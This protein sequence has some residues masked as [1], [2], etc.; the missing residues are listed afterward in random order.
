LKLDTLYPS[1]EHVRITIEP[2][3]PTEFSVKLRIPAW[4]RNA[5]VALNGKDLAIE[6]QSDGY[7]RIQRKWNNSD[8]I[9]LTLKLEP[10]VVLGN[11]RNEGKIAVMYGP[12]VLAADGALISADEQGSSS[13]PLGA[14]AAAGPTLQAL[15]F[16]TEP[17]PRPVKSWDG[18]EVFRINAI[19]RRPVGSLPAGSPAIARLVPFSDAGGIGSDYKVWL[20]LR[21]THATGNLLLEGTEARSRWG[22]LGGSI[23]DEDFHSAVVTFDGKPAKEDW[24]CVTLTQPETIGRVVF[25]HGKSFHDGGW[26]DSSTGKPRVQVRTAPDGPWQTLGELEQYPATTADSSAGLREGEPFSFT[27]KEPVKAYAVRVIG[28]PATGDNPLQAFAS[29]SELQAFPH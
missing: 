26:F 11:H 4:C 23:N 17:A 18:A 25:A 6:E 28:K 1:E 24:F 14:I 12:L 3:R 10:G 7:M 22:N 8:R 19:T 21:T 15:N 2:T 5:K 29:C 27:L 16:K 20:P 13:L 9:D